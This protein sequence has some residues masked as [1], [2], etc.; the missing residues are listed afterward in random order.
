MENFDSKNSDRFRGRPF[1]ARRAKRR[2]V[3][4]SVYFIT[5]LFF[6]IYFFVI[7][8]FSLPPPAA[9]PA[10]VTSR[11]PEPRLQ[12]IEGEVEEGSNLFQSLT[13]RNIPPQWI[14]LII[15]ELTA[16]GY[17][18]STGLSTWPHLDYRV[19]KDGQFR[20]PLK[21][22]F[23]AG[24]PIGSGEIGPFDQRRDEMLVWLQGESPFWKK[25]EKGEWKLSG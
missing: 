8:S 1:E 2:W 15:S 25:V 3:L 18:G 16:Y 12:T 22:G 19:S 21:E 11:S 23:P 24:L 14:D 4:L 7:P 13:E 17:V 9:P 20:N 6:L 10:S 5:G